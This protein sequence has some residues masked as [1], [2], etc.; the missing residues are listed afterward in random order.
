MLLDDLLNRERQF[1]INSFDLLNQSA[2]MFVKK[3][4]KENS[5]SIQKSCSVKAGI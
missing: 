4:E 1:L 2:K 5:D 3:T